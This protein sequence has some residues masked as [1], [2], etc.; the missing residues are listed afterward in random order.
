MWQASIKSIKWIGAVV[1]VVLLLVWVGSRW[2]GFGLYTRS[3]SNLAGVFG[4]RLVLV[5]T[6]PLSSQ[7]RDLRGSFDFQVGTQPFHW[8]F[9]F[10]SDVSSRMREI[11]IPTWS[12]ALLTATPTVWLW[13]RDRRR[14]RAEAAN[15]CR[16]CGY[17]RTG[18]PADRACPECGTR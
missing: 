11:A 13:R 15:C 16:T 10:R 8:W 7:L 1:T 3:S 4:G 9:E 14:R 18:L 6:M 2:Y 17:S 5:W 12:L